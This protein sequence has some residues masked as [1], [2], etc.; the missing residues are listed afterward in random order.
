MDFILLGLVWALLVALPAGRAGAQQTSAQAQAEPPAKEAPAAT[1]EQAPAMSPESTPT[2]PNKAPAPPEAPAPAKIHRDTQVTVGSS[3]TIKKGEVARDVVV[4]SGSLR[5]EGQVIG[6]AVAVGG[7]AWID[8]EVTGDVTA[9]GGSVHLGPEAQVLGDVN[10]IGGSVHRE[11]GAKVLGQVNNVGVGPLVFRGNNH[12]FPHRTEHWR[13]RWVEGW[14]PM[15]HVMLLFWK[16]LEIMVLM[17]FACLALVLFPRRLERVEDRLEHEPWKAALVGLGAEILFAPLLLAV[18]VLLAVSIIGIPLLLLVPFMIL[19]FFLT[20]FFGFTASAHRIGRWAEDRFSWH[21]GNPYLQM[22]VGVG[23]IIVISLC[24]R[25]IGLGG[26]FLTFFSV[27]LLI[28]GWL[29]QYVAWTVG[30]GAALLSRWG[31][32][33]K[34]ETAALPAPSSPPA[35]SDGGST[36]GDS[37]QREEDLFAEPDE[38]DPPE[39]AAPRT[40]DTKGEAPDTTR[41]ED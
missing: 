39:P 24:G 18:V 19:A 32:A 17:L 7:S 5:V 1:A 10:A 4:F 29:V 3:L 35:G 36:G 9:V 16:I 8:G 15:R 13:N 14:S 11:E 6:D 26:G 30:L 12:V 25:I 20:A 37:T 22:V 41:E 2:P 31:A 40:E 28:I 34:G 27:S 21:F 38:G 23:L 33:P